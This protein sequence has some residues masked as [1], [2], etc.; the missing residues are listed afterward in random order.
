MITKNRYRIWTASSCLILSTSVIPRIV[1]NQ[2]LV[3]KHY[4]KRI[5]HT[6]KIHQVSD[7]NC[8]ILLKCI[9]NPNQLIAVYLKALEDTIYFYVAISGHI[10]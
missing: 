7:K 6:A 1:D 5:N 3:N 2:Y 9:H 10:I 4:L 8:S